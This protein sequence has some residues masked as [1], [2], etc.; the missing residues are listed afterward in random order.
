MIHRPAFQSLFGR[1]SRRDVLRVGAGA[2][3]SFLLPT[4][5]LKATERR[6]VERP[7]SLIVL[8]M[9]GGMSQL[10][11]W[12]PHPDSKHA[13]KSAGAIDT[14]LP[15]LQ[16]SSLLPRMA[17]QIHHLSVIR[18]LVSKEGDHE[19]ATYYAQTG[20]RPDPTVVHPALTALVA[21]YLTDD[22]VEIPAH[23]MLADGGGFVTPRGGYLGAHGRRP[24]AAARGGARDGFERIP[25]A[26]AAR[27]RRDAAP[28][29]R[30]AGADHDDLRSA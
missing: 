9:A 25:P 13:G 21:K 11:S 28:A 22:K 4:L 18:S 16:I 7:K 1:L 19:R 15:G 23:V 17:E 8:W 27:E 12:D 10:E 6:G 30:P 5:D 26:A 29:R 3:L 24:S 2:G 20:Y 14:T